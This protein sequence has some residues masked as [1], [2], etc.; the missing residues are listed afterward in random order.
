MLNVA[1]CSQGLCSPD[2]WYV[3]GTGEVDALS[4]ENI[5]EK[6]D[7]ILTGPPY[8]GVP[9]EPTCIC[10][11]VYVGTSVN[12]ENI[13]MLKRQRFTHVL[14]VDGF[15]LGLA[16]KRRA[17]F[18]NSGIVY[19]ELPIDDNH[20]FD[21]WP[22]F[23]PAHMFIDSGRYI[24][25]V[26]IVDSGV[27]RSG[28]IALSYMI[29][30]GKCLLAATRILKDDRRVVLHHRYFMKRLV[31]YARGHGMLDPT[32]EHVKDPRTYGRAIDK[33]RIRSIHLTL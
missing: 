7:N 20:N 24:G 16:S 2:G 29:K 1:Y 19:E 13:T 21:I 22:Y 28:A 14:N 17:A 26:L 30:A 4:D 18:K 23:H 27:N 9:R 10:S 11:N 5:I 33:Y 15:P 3:L 12:G 8:L 25:K 6:M 32:L 31:A